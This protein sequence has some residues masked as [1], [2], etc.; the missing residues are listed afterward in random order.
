MQKMPVEWQR[1]MVELLVEIEPLADEMGVDSKYVILCRDDKGHFKRP[2]L[3][4][5]RYYS[6]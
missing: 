4:N 5:Y 6:E 3:C 1:K 2:K